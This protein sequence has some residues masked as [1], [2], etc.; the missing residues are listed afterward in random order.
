M[1]YAPVKIRNP[2]NESLVRLLPNQNVHLIFDRPEYE[3]VLLTC[4]SEFIEYDMVA[5]RPEKKL[6]AYRQKRDFSDWSRVSNVAFGSIIVR[7]AN[8]DDL[9]L[10]LVLKSTNK[11]DV[12]TVINPNGQIVIEPQQTLHVVLYDAVDPL[13]VW[14]DSLDWCANGLKLEKVHWSS[15]SKSSYK[16]DESGQLFCRLPRAE[17]HSECRLRPCPT[18]VQEQH[19]WFRFDSHSLRWLEKLE[20]GTHVVC[21]L[22]FR[23]KPVSN[24]VFS[25]TLQVNVNL[26]HRNRI[27]TYQVVFQNSHRPRMPGPCRQK[28]TI[29]PLDY[30]LDFGCRSLQIKR[31]S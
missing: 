2:Q 9:N 27:Q 7:R 15:V 14:K 21:S 8:Q 22:A 31:Y 3:D 28:V 17:V 16:R 26:T 13:T 20:N 12:I 29:K 4:N 5:S 6:F 1:Q 30:S 23:N 11:S 18:Y 10:N 25:H 19:Y 24:I